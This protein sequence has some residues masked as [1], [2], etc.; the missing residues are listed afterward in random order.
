MPSKKIRIFKYL[1]WTLAFVGLFLPI[2]IYIGVNYK[3]FFTKK[4]S[5]SIAVG[6]SLS[7]VAIA[8]LIKI[9]FKKINAV[10]WAGFLVA[11]A[12]CFDSIME[13]MLAITCMI[14]LGTLI[15][16][17]FK[18]PAMY[19]SKRLETFT[20]VNDSKQAEKEYEEKQSTNGSV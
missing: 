3:I 9:G 15:F 14:F 17:I 12:Y 16:T 18:L 10:W 20:R 13:H 19:F 5:I 1:F 6:G 7:F 11:I 8:L 4:E 2:T